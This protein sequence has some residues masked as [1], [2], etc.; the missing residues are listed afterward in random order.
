MDVFNQGMRQGFEKSVYQHLQTSYP[1]VVK[2]MSDD[3]IYASIST[4]I[5]RSASYGITAEYDV[6]RFVD[7]MYLL[8]ADF[9]SNPRWNWI[10]PILDDTQLSSGEKMDLIYDKA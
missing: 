10:G 8:S 1:E 6:V 3:A 4:G 2:N 7:L 9:D 5:E